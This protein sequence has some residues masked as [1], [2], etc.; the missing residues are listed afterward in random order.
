MS[1]ETI[2]VH[3]AVKDGKLTLSPS[4]LR[5]SNA[6]DHRV[7]W[8]A[9][10]GGS[11][12]IRF[13]E[14]SPFESSVF[15]SEG[16]AEGVRPGPIRPGARDK[17]FDYEIVLRARDQVLKGRGT[18][19]IGDVPGAGKPPKPPG[20]VRAYVRIS[21][22]SGAVVVDQ[23]KVKVDRNV[24]EQVE[25]SCADGR[26]KIKFDYGDGTPFE[27]DEH[28]GAAVTPLKSGGCLEDASTGEYRY[29]I[30]VWPTTGGGPLELDPIV[31]VE[32][33]GDD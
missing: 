20:A 26:F 30:K 25:W 15:N 7:A 6:S 32:D 27:K 24:R 16:N 14:E 12:E 31:E 10:E 28:D 29:R 33:G 18:L 5:V 2:P 3:V 8:V 22:V 13:V 23:D 4:Q 11:L 19:T 21:V 9:D 1:M 17:K